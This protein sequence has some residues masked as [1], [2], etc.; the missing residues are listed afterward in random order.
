ML[1]NPHDVFRGQS[2]SPN[3]VTFFR[4]G[5]VSYYCSIETSSPRHT[6]FD[7]VTFEKYSDLETRTRSH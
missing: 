4:L 2:R 3:Q 1:T 5:T 6:I 7:I